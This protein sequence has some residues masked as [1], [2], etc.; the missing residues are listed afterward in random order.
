MQQ[1]ETCVSHYAS[2]DYSHFAVVL[3]GRITGLTPSV[4]SSVPL[5][6]PLRGLLTEK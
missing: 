4:R 1:I 5:S 2:Y 3:I 6:V